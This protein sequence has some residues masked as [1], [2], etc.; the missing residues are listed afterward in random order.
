MD[1][2]YGIQ[3]V[4]RVNAIRVAGESTTSESLDCDSLVPSVAS[5]ISTIF[6]HKTNIPSVIFP[7][8]QLR[9]RSSA[10]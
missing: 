3:V 6:P 1:E 10:F 5:T 8:V 4:G 9:I 7:R 2:I